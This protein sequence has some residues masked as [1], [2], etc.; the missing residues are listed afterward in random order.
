MF[1]LIFC[2]VI[3]LWVYYTAQCT[4]C[5]PHDENIRHYFNRM[6]IVSLIMWFLIGIR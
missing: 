3:F 2:L 4:H 6:I 1:N 5:M